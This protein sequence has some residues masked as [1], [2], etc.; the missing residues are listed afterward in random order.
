MDFVC[1]RFSFAI[2]L[3]L[4]SFPFVAGSTGDTVCGAPWE[5][6]NAACFDA[7]SSRV[8]LLGDDVGCREGVCAGELLCSITPTLWPEGETIAEGVINASTEPNKACTIE[9]VYWADGEIMPVGIG[10]EVCFFW[11]RYD[12]SSSYDSPLV[13]IMRSC[14]DSKGIDG[15]GATTIGASLQNEADVPSTAFGANHYSFEFFR[16]IS[17]ESKGVEMVV[18]TS[19]VHPP[20][21][22]GDESGESTAFTFTALSDSHYLVYEG[23]VVTTTVKNSAAEITQSDYLATSECKMYIQQITSSGVSIVELCDGVPAIKP[24]KSLLFLNNEYVIH[25]RIV[26]VVNLSKSDT[27][28]SNAVLKIG[29]ASSKIAALPSI[30]GSQISPLPSVSPSSTDS[31]CEYYESRQGHRCYLRQGY[32]YTS[33]SDCNSGEL[34]NSDSHQCIVSVS[35]PPSDWFSNFFEGIGN[36]FKGLFGNK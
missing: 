28:L 5:E 2:L 27:G 20:I 16:R 17:E 33:D 7:I 14:T 21:V 25:G 15:V 30:N 11:T 19:G 12:F 23:N 35:K 10:L 29:G 3:V 32:C 8:S 34:C 4:L 26:S 18:D 6:S 36:F 9:S 22:L 13:F 31:S 24:E 1:Q